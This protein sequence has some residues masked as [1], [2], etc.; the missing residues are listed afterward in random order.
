[1]CYGV[2]VSNPLMLGVS[3]HEFLG[4]ALIPD[5]R[6]ER[7]VLKGLGDIAVAILQLASHNLLG[8][9]FP[10]HICRRR[11]PLQGGV[12]DGLVGNSFHAKINC[13]SKLSGMKLLLHNLSCAGFLTL[14]LVKSYHTLRRFSRFPSTA[15]LPHSAI[16]PI[17]PRRPSDCHLLGSS[18]QSA[19]PIAL[20]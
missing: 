9:S 18:T 3:I 6:M 12:L 15:K 17:R 2:I 14:S 7:L 16:D 1:M 10:A 20:S 19:L 13:H 11:L 5:P 8:E 4:I